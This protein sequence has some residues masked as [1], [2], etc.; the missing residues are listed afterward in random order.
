MK[1]TLLTAIFSLTVSS[2]SLSA[3]PIF[4][5]FN[6]PTGL[7]GTSQTYTSNGITITAYGY[8]GGALSALYGK[9]TSVQ[10]SGLGLAAGPTHEIDTYDFVQLDLANLIAA[11][12]HA[13]VDVK[14]A[15]VDNGDKFNIYGSATQGS[16][17]NLLL[18][19]STLDL[20]NF[21]LPGYGTYRYFSFQATGSGHDVLLNSVMVVPEPATWGLIGAGLALAA[22]KRKK[23]VKQ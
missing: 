2:L 18:S 4:F 7:L 16:L 22:F 10:D 20:T 11:A 9:N 8:N 21:A 15:S 23:L 3:A 19:N 12:P 13:Q 17:G 14:M 6:N 1:N 5:T